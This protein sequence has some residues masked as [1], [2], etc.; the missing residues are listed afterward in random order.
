[1]RNDIVVPTSGL[2]S[3]WISESGPNSPTKSLDMVN[4]NPTPEVLNS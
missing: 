3:T 4:P 1:M 2:E